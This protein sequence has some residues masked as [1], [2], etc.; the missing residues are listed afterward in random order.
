MIATQSSPLQ[1]QDP[2]QRIF[3]GALMNL[4]VGTATLTPGLLG[5]PVKQPGCG[6]PQLCPDSPW[7]LAGGRLPKQPGVLGISFNCLMLPW[8]PADVVPG[9][10]GQLGQR[11]RPHTRWSSKGV[12]LKK[13]PRAKEAP[14]WH[15]C[16]PPIRGGVMADLWCAENPM[17]GRKGTCKQHCVTEAWRGQDGPGEGLP[18]H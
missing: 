17:W 14:P 15:C 11:W 7:G 6:L 1:C 18:S 4:M 13:E 12:R 16:D 5:L 9:I 2:S 8:T 3:A 10:C